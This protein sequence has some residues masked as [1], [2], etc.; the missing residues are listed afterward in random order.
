MITLNILDVNGPSL[1]DGINVHLTLETS[2]K[3]YD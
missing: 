3:G 1:G 2:E